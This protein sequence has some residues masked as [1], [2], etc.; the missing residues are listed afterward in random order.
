MSIN[1]DWLF[2]VVPAVDCVGLTAVYVYVF[3]QSN[4]PRVCVQCF[5]RTVRYAA[6]HQNR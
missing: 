2:D 5:D 3:V 4:L 1:S 6:I